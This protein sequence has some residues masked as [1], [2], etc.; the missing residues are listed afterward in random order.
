MPK[1][2]SWSD[3]N[4]TLT[5]LY[6]SRAVFLNIKMISLTIYNRM[7]LTW[8]IVFC[9]CQIAT[10]GLL[11]II[12]L[13]VCIMKIT[14]LYAVCTCLFLSI[15]SKSDINMPFDGT[16]PS[17]FGTLTFGIETKTFFFGEGQ[18]LFFWRED[19]KIT[20]LFNMAV[21]VL[22]KTLSLLNKNRFGGGIKPT[23]CGNIK[24]KSFFNTTVFVQRTLSLF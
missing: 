22:R 15:K 19:V 3:D 6:V 24:I 1:S 18:H 8:M 14:W 7:T 17:S 2:N 21:F 5:V 11:I 12:T 23:K 20:T 9:R 10:L 4:I 13:T 16:P